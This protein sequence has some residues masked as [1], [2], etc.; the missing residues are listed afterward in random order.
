[1]L[2]T[3]EVFLA[4]SPVLLLWESPAFIKAKPAKPPQF[5]YCLGKSSVICYHVCIIV[6]LK[7]NWKAQIGYVERRLLLGLSLDLAFT[8][9]KAILVQQPPFSQNQGSSTP[10][11]E[12]QTSQLYHN[13]ISIWPV[14][15]SAMSNNLPIQ[16]LFVI[17]SIQVARKGRMPLRTAGPAKY[18]RRK[19]REGKISQNSSWL[20]WNP[21]AEARG[22]LHNCI[23]GCTTL[24]F[25]DCKT[26][27]FTNLKFPSALQLTITTRINVFYQYNFHTCH[28]SSCFPSIAG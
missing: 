25:W 21:L 19:W 1:M 10:G 6:F 4:L 8:I 15:R 2:W 16:L 17:P 7:T 3:I 12:H 27:S 13:L 5:L 23:F 22:E 11:P 26:A 24:P 18:P 20:I 9:P 28:Y 14:L